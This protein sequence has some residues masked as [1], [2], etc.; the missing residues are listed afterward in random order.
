MIMIK[1]N[2]TMKVILKKDIKYKMNITMRVILK[3]DIK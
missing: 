2:I 3:K 1:M